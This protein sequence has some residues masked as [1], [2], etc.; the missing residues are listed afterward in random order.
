METKTKHFIFVGYPAD[1]RSGFGPRKLFKL[2]IKHYFLRTTE[3]VKNL[4]YMIIDKRVSIMIWFPLE[5]L[6]EVSHGS[7]LI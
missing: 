6:P 4:T 5:W 7:V 3:F 2:E 1:I